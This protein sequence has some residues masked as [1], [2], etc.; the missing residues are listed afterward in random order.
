MATD[1]ALK[2]YFDAAASWDVDRSAQTVRRLRMAWTVATAGWTCA[3][4][5]SVALACLTPLK[6]TVPYVIR[7]DNTTGVVDVVP[8]Y[9]GHAEIGESVARFLL[10]HYVTEC[11]GF[12]YESAERSYEECSAY[13][14]AKRNQEWYDQWN[15]VNPKSPLN[16]YKDGTTVRAQVT[17]IS[18]FTRANGVNALAQVRYVKGTRP[19]GG[20]ETLTHWIATIEYAYGEPSKNTR[21]RQWNPLGFRIISFRPEPEIAADASTLPNPTASGSTP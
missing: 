15:T 2:A 3:L 9:A 20:T 19:P 12:D 18:F 7:V 17:S 6:Q 1:E 11:E 16:R 14:T 8:I 10:T 13:H 4:G 21:M 5:G